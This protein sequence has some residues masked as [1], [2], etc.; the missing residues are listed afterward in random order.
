MSITELFPALTL[1]YSDTNYSQLDLTS[2]PQFLRD[3]INLLKQAS[4][5]PQEIIHQTA[6][7]TR[8]HRRET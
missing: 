3:K 2:K 4:K 6:T 5:A 7:H 8:S 1:R